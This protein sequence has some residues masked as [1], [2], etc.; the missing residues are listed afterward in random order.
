MTWNSELIQWGPALDQYL[1]YPP[2]P[3]IAMILLDITEELLF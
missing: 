3:S 2:G 1:S